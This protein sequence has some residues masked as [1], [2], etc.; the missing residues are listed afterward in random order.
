MKF[1]MK[2]VLKFHREQE[3]GAKAKVCTICGTTIHGRLD[4]HMKSMHNTEKKFQCDKCDY[5]LDFLKE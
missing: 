1:P 2:V 4:M 5:R 3:H